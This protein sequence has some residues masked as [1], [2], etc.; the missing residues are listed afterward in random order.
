MNLF[1]TEDSSATF[2]PCGQ[3]RYTLTREWD[4]GER[5]AWLMMN[6]STADA[7]VDDPTI[8]KCIG[9]SKR[10]GYGSLVV[11]NLFAIRSTY[12]SV[13]NRTTTP[14]GPMNDC[15]I[16]EALQGC[17]ELICAWGCGEQ[18]IGNNAYRP[19]QLLAKI[20]N[21]WIE[22]VLPI[23]CLGRRK[24]GQPRHPSRLAYSTPRENY[25]W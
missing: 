1:G 19:T 5:V 10:W 9:F 6:P 3:Y 2:S 17:R 18:L 12:P 4:D 16:M 23:R 8:R 15:H 20:R 25:I 14:V 13:I 11:V 7:R 21:E 24:D 22:R